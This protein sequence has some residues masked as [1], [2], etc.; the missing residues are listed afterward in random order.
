LTGLIH[1]FRAWTC[2]FS[3]SRGFLR[4]A[5]DKLVGYAKKI[6]QHNEPRFI[7]AVILAVEAEEFSVTLQLGKHETGAQI[8]GHRVHFAMAEKSPSD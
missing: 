8:F 3:C 5:A 4:L 2:L 6:V 7:N 1:S